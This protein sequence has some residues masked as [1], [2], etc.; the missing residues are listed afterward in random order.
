MRKKAY[1][2]I[3]VIAIMLLIVVP[4]FLTTGKPYVP[5]LWAVL[6]ARR[7]HLNILFMIILFVIVVY[8][9]YKLGWHKEKKTS[10]VHL[11]F[12]IPRN[13]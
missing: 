10:Q 13:E 2:Y 6:T 5:N 3:A 4:N 7:Y 8:V 1:I 9:G 11:P 12:I